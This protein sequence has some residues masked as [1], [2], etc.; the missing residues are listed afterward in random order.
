MVWEEVVAAFGMGGWLER[1]VY[2]IRVEKVDY[3]NEIYSW[4]GGH[5]GACLNG[6][7]RCCIE[8]RRDI[9]SRGVDDCFRVRFVGGG[10]GVH[11]RSCFGLSYQS[12][13]HHRR[14][15]EWRTVGN[16]SRCVYRSAS[17]GRN[18]WLCIAVVDYRHNGDGRYGSQ[19]FWRAVSAGC[20]C[21]R[22]GVYV[23]LRAD[24]IGHY[25]PG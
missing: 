12:G 15:A 23:H 11:N 22:G 2:L 20:I 3:E 1:I 16:G 24:C 14:L 13:H 10:N 4:N 7:R 19:R 21:C 17:D 25:R 8:W 9:G 6:M 18:T 5:Y